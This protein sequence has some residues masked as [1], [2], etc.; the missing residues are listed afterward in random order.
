MMVFVL[1]LSTLLYCEV[2]H[3]WKWKWKDLLLQFNKLNFNVRWD[4]IF[5]AVIS[6]F[7]ML[8]LI[9]GLTNIIAKEYSEVIK[10]TF[11]EA[12]FGNLADFT[13]IIA[14]LLRYLP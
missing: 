11:I 13:G 12:Y 6:F 7:S 8:L 14:Y 9:N 5:S 3:I 1:V 10:L 4:N 2:S